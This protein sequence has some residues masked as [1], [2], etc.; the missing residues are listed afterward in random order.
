LREK[1]FER[2]VDKNKNIRKNKSRKLEED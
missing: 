2:F 1:G